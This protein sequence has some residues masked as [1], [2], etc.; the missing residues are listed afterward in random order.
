[1][2]F[3]RLHLILSAGGLS[4]YERFEAMRKLNTDPQSGLY[5][6]LTNKWFIILGWSLIFVLILILAAI[7]QQHKEKNKEK[8]RQAFEEKANL[9]GL[10]NEEREILCSIARLARLKS[11]H[12]IYFRPGDFETGMTRFLQRVLA[13]QP[14]EEFRKQ[15][16]E[17]IESI[18]YKIGFVRKN[19][20]YKGRY[21][22]G[23]HLTSRQIPVEEEVSVIPNSLPSDQ[24]YKATVTSNEV[25]DLGLCA[26]A[27]LPFRAGDA[28]TIRYM[29]G[30]VLWGFDVIVLHCEATELKVCHVD[31]ARYINRRRFVRVPLHQPIWIAP[32]PVLSEGTKPAIPSFLKIEILEFSGT[33]L[34]VRGVMDVER[35]DRV[36][37]VFEVEPGRMVQDIAEVQRIGETE[38]GPF[39]ILELTGLDDRS[40]NE[41]IRITN[42]LAIEQGLDVDVEQVLEG[43]ELEMAMEANG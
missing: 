38:T 18:K 30:A 10:T 3:P 20:S 22:R 42:Q 9:F 15:Q 6:L 19:I 27:P 1:M 33:T 35:R 7:R 11:Y 29:I 36:L 43:E 13:S 39:Y 21:R 31:H 40:E 28:C 24:E 4:P 12:N 16:I 5:A 37:V 14:N 32:F 26:S 17:V 34:R 25:T 23:N 41:L 2:I 8:N